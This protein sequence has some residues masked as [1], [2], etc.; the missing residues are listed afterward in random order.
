MAGGGGERGCGGGRRQSLAGCT[1]C[2]PLF[3]SYILQHNTKPT[4]LQPLPRLQPGGAGGGAQGGGR[5][6]GRRPPGGGVPGGG[7][8]AARRRTGA[9][10]G[11]SPGVLW[12][13]GAATW[14]AAPGGT[15]VAS[16]VCTNSPRGGIAGALVAACWLASMLARD[17]LAGGAVDTPV[18]AD[19]CA[20]ARHAGRRA[21]WLH[22]GLRCVGAARRRRQ[23]GRA[24]RRRWRR[25]R[26]CAAAAG[27]GCIRRVHHHQV[28]Q[29]GGPAWRWVP[30]KWCACLAGRR[31]LPGRGMH[32]H[33][34]LPHGCQPSTSGCRAR[35]HAC[36]CPSPL[37]PPAPTPRRRRASRRAFVRQR[38][39]MGAGD[40]LVELGAVVDEIAATAQA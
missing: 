10:A 1:S 6:C 2:S 3:S 31:F 30:W 8:A 14:G 5:R 34:W 24:A 7:V 27:A 23:Q 39:S 11:C 15:G 40:L 20:C 32:K 33:A 22:R 28:G 9:Q 17:T 18:P 36:P 4:P 16:V 25:R 38:R 35:A 19:L 13:W 12:G 29:G 26:P 21:V 37:R